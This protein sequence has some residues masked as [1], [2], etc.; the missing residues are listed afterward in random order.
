[1][2]EVE[3]ARDG[4]IDLLPYGRFDQAR[5]TPYSLLFTMLDTAAMAEQLWDRLLT[6]SQREVVA[7]G[8]GLPAGQA[9]AVV[10]LLAGLQPVGMLVPDYQ[11]RQPRV[12]P[13]LSPELTGQVPVPGRPVELARMSM[14]MA[15]G[16]LAG[17]GFEVAG[18]AS[19]A[20]RAAQVVGSQAG[21]FLQV[22][23]AGAAAPGRVEV[24]AGGGR[25]QEL[26]WRYA[27]LV[28]HLTGAAA[29]PV[30]FTVAAAVLAAGVVQLSSRLAA[31]EA[32]W[33]DGAHM[34]AFGAGEH[35]S[36]ARELCAQQI[37]EGQWQRAE[38]EE[39]PFAVAHPQAGTP[40]AMQASLMQALPGLVDRYG[41]G[42]LVV[43]DVTGGGKGICAL[44]AARIFNERLGTRG[45]LWLM[46]TTATA[47]AAWETLEWYVRAH[48]PDHALPV[49]LAHSHRLLN[50]AYT[51]RLLSPAGGQQAGEPH[52]GDGG[53]SDATA[54]GVFSGSTQAALLAQFCA[55]TID[56]ALMAVLPVDSS[57]QRLLAVSGKTVVID[58]AHA[59]EPFS[60]T[61]LL[62]L[63][64]WLGA[65]RTPVVVLSATLADSA[66]DALAHAYLQGRRAADDPALP[67]AHEGG[68]GPQPE[69]GSAD[70]YPGWLF[71]DAAAGVHRMEPG[72]A[73]AHAAARRRRVAL[74]L[75]P[76]VRRRLGPDEHREIGAGERLG[77]VTGLLGPVAGQ[78]GC[79]A[80]TCATV[81][82]AQDTYR[83]L[84]DAFPDLEG[85]LVLLHARFPGL[86]RAARTAALRTALARGGPRPGRLV[87]V[88]TSVLD[89]SMNLDFDLMISDLASAALLL[90][91]LGRLARFDWSGAAGGR[92]GVRRPQWW[93]AGSPAAFHVLRP[94]SGSGTTA[95]PAAWRTL[96]PAVILQATADLLESR[97]SGL[98]HLPDDVQG[99]VEAVHGDS[100]VFA[101]PGS[102]LA[103]PAAAL[104]HR[105]T[106]ESHL[107]G[108]HLIPPPARV[109]SL[110]DLHRQHLT[111]AQAA[112]RLGPAPVRLL[113]CYV[114]TDG[115]R[116]LDRAGRHPLPESAPLAA[117]DVRR[118]L[119]HTLPVPAAWAAA[120]TRR[121][122]PP[123]SW[124]HRLLRDLVL[125]PAPADDPHHTE[126]F[127]RYGLRMDDNLGLVTTRTA[128]DPTPAPAG[129][130]TTN[131][132]HTLPLDD[133]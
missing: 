127:G 53:D 108:L 45:V 26:R 36:R 81:S 48:E 110:A 46:P 42:F 30:R 35:F 129:P 14:H 61:Q 62:R 95:I 106:G 119:G 100:T 128:F 32:V 86:V 99:L 27:R 60:R 11:R 43:R 15:V 130:P 112:T 96:E 59:P 3:D 40:N 6:P 92:D 76:V 49:G 55:A 52:D 56:Q 118:I 44:E 51:D 28:R 83:C 75:H 47:D 23:V 41:G 88:T 74:R 58:E 97:G 123:A 113:P 91:R 24:V 85:Q 12:W 126:Q 17:F 18:N 63:L 33:L 34:P 67:P 133:M 93:T 79:A 89:T 5:E 50:T 10:A 39:I 7:R 4:G 101:R 109:S 132:T 1:M 80:V 87:V 13:R 72:T 82:D 21:V 57:A 77:A 65:L 64:T 102:P 38:L 31:R 104:Q 94:V 16:L 111:T 84:R 124:S 37:D 78:G 20:V 90:Q 29:V 103:T 120:R 9:R 69:E 2:G 116:T 66:C 8:T 54:P 121:H 19:A 115:R 114:H 71:V 122:Q 70:R 107:S 131:V 25:W 125:L 68:P 117:G 98:L 22:D 105:Q 73:R